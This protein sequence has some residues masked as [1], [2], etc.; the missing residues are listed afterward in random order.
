MTLTP[1]HFAAVI[2]FAIVCFD[3][4]RHYATEYA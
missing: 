1:S 3:H 4:L 2:L